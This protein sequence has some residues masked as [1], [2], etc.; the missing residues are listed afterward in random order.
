MNKCLTL[1]FLL[2]DEKLKIQMI[3][4]KILISKTFWV[5]EI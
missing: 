1:L 2:H 3:H 5:S 4:I